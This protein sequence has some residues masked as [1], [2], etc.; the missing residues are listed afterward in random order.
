MLLHWCGWRPALVAPHSL[1][2]THPHHPL[3]LSSAWLQPV[4]L[5][6]RWLHRQHHHPRRLQQ[7]VKEGEGEDHPQKAQ[8]V[9]LEDPL[10]E[11]EDPQKLVVALVEGV[12]QAEL[13]D[14]LMVE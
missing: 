2:T 10:E 8:G 13:E 4:R 1:E 12:G 6:T 14:H 9:D 7:T 5:P 11:L 3:P